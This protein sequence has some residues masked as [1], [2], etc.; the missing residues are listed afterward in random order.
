MHVKRII[1]G[2]TLAA[3]SAVSAF[4]ADLPARAPPPMP[5]PPAIYNWTGFYLGANAGYGWGHQNPLSLLS[6]QFDQATFNV[7]GGMIGAT[8]GAQIQASH[9]VM[10]LEADGDWASVKGS[11]SF[12]PTIAGVPLPFAL[13]LN[14]SA[15]AYYTGRARVG[16]AM[17][18]VLLYGT[19]GA[20]MLN[21]SVT[22]NSVPA[23]TCGTAGVLPRCSGSSTRLG[24]A[25]GAGAEYGFMPNMSAKAEYIWSG[26]A[27]GAGTESLN[28]F[29]VG[30]NYRFG[31]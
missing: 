26:F 11:S 15:S 31:G 1:V 9:I 28:L 17:D 23:A 7:H 25:A 10:G 4:S 16:Y 24:V 21:S 3:A 30:L 12:T 5:A 27:V 22:G 14:S 2:V 6:T 20:A 13:G 29:R 8:L 18:N 19:G